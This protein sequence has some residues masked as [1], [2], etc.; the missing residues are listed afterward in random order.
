MKCGR[1]ARYAAPEDM[2]RE[3]SVALSPVLPLLVCSVRSAREGRSGGR[4]GRLTSKFDLPRCAR[5]SVGRPN[6]VFREVALKFNYLSQKLCTAQGRPCIPYPALTTALS[7]L[8]TPHVPRGGSM[9]TSNVLSVV[10]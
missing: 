9:V 1:T 8:H 4:S 2:L 7:P 10:P 3:G 6:R 5:R